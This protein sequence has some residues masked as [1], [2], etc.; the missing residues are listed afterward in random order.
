[1]DR[2]QTLQNSPVAQPQDPASQPEQIQVLTP[3]SGESNGLT[4]R[5]ARSQTPST[6]L[7][8]PTSEG[9][10]THSRSHENPYADFERVPVPPPP[11]GRDGHVRVSSR[12]QTL[13]SN[14]GL[15]T[16]PHNTSG[17]DWIV[18]MEEK[19][20]VSVVCFLD[21]SD[22]YLVHGTTLGAP[23]CR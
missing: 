5:D 16:A 1:M 18:P 13:T 11:R 19:G 23:H 20:S 14:G 12:R 7:R 21:V 4:G 22:T 10:L 3:D 15:P 6:H 17:I 9:Y 2:E 8:N